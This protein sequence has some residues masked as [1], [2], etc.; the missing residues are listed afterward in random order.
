MNDEIIFRPRMGYLTY[1]MIITVIL[2]CILSW[3]FID[4]WSGSDD[5]WFFFMLFMMVICAQFFPIALFFIRVKYIFRTESLIVRRYL[6]SYEIRYRSI[7]HVEEMTDHS[8]YILNITPSVPSSKQI[9]IWY[10]DKDGSE[11]NVNICPREKEEFLSQL[12]YRVD[13]KAFIIEASSQ[14]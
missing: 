8:I 1:N 2:V 5:F 6:S 4:M 3:L 10:T 12:R 14:R 13:P 11:Q 9:L 7:T